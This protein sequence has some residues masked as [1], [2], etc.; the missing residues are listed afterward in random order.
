MYRGFLSDDVAIK[1]EPNSSGN[2]DLFLFDIGGNIGEAYDVD[3]IRLLSFMNMLYKVTSEEIEDFIYLD[4]I[5]YPE[6]RSIGS[7]SK[8]GLGDDLKVGIGDFEFE[9]LNEELKE[10]GELVTQLIEYL[11]C[12][13]LPKEV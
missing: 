3:A 5:D 12:C 7:L 6:S 2:L 8:P 4:F 1:I 10:T 13:V 11:K 9:V